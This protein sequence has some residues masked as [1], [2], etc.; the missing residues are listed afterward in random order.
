MI[1]GFFGFWWCLA[2][3]ALSFTL[4][5]QAIQEGTVGWAWMDGIAV[6]LWLSYA[7]SAKTKDALEEDNDND[8]DNWSPP[9][10]SSTR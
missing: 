8:S 9:N 10:G 5:I 3:A 7:W 4:L 1:R 6:V 2:F